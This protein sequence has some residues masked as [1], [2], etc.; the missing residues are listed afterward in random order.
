MCEHLQALTG[1]GRFLKDH[2]YGDANVY[3]EALRS[4]VFGG[5]HTYVPK[6][7][8]RRFW[9]ATREDSIIL[10]AWQATYGDLT[11]APTP[12]VYYSGDVDVLVAYDGDTE[13]VFWDH[14]RDV[15]LIN[16]DAKKASTW[17]FLPHPT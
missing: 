6:D 9:D 3:G 5:H 8:P 16:D 13:V 1:F 12:T 4:Y 10:R 17:R 15:L 14:V 11:D 2:T 7:Y